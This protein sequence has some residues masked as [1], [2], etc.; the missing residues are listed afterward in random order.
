MQREHD[1]VQPDHRR[2]FK[3]CLKKMSYDLRIN[4]F[5]GDG[6]GRVRK[7]IKQKYCRDQPPSQDKH[8]LR[9]TP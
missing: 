6:G 8:Y 5:K 9:M 1:M 2:I 3:I 7:G 4:F